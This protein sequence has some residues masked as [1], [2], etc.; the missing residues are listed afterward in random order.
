MVEIQRKSILFRVSARF[1]LLGLNCIAFIFL[2]FLSF[3]FFFCFVLGGGD[4]QGFF[5]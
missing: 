5:S 1:E 2:S 4:S 3:F